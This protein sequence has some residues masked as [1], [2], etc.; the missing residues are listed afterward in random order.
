MVHL[1]SEVHV[2]GNW[3]QGKRR[4]EGTDALSLGPGEYVYDPPMKR[5]FCMM[6]DGE[7]GQFLD[8]LHGVEQYDDG[9]ISTRSLLKGRRRWWIMDSGRWLEVPRK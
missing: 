6:P 4:P 8:W 9:T 7:L 3:A 1:V 2:T 5:W